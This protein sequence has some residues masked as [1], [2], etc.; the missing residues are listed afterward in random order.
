MITVTHNGADH[1]GLVFVMRKCRRLECNLLWR[2][3]HCVCVEA[4]GNPP[5]NEDVET[6]N[7]LYYFG[8]TIKQFGKSIYLKGA[9][10][11]NGS[12]SGGGFARC[13]QH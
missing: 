11:I 13:I 9:A 8:T 12:A 2:L 5:D 7:W 10:N 4:C 3:P 1:C 6:K